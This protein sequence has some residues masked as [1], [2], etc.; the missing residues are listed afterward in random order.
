[1]EDLYKKLDADPS[2][3]K[4]FEQAI[5]T[6][7]KEAYTRES[8]SNTVYLFLQR[9]LDRINRLKLFWYDDLRHYTNARSAC[10]RNV[11]DRIK[12]AWQE[13]E[14]SCESSNLSL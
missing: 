13:W 11:G 4:N 14:L 8:G 5:A 1:L 9:V 10:L 2:S 12:A 7:I 6:A 3:A